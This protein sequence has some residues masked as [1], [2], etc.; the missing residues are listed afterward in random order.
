MQKL[1]PIVHSLSKLILLFSGVLCLPA[2]VSLYYDD[3]AILDFVF[4]AGFGAA[5]GLGLWLASRQHGKKKELKP[6]DGFILVVLLWFGFAVTASTP[7]LLFDANL[8]F[9]DAMFESMSALTTTGATIMSG[10]DA[11]PPSIN[12]WRHFLN[13]IGGM[14]IIVLAVAILPLLGVGGMQLYKAETP[15]P[16]KDSKL[17]PRIAQ[18]AKHLWFIYAVITLACALC[19][20]AA[21]MSWFDAVCHAMATL[22]LGGFSTHDASVGYFNSV[23]IEVILSCF[24]VIAAT[25]FAMHFVAW[26]KKSL[27]IYLKDTETFSMIAL[28]LVSILVMSVYLWHS[29]VY[30]FTVALRHVSFNLISIATCSGFA[31]VNFGVWPMFVPLWMLFLSGITASSGSTGGGI[32]MI[33][34]LIL[35]KQGWRE[36]GQLLHPQAYLPLKINKKI[37][38]DSVIFSVLGF[39]FVYFIIVIAST[40]ILLA[41]GLDLLTAFSATIACINNA[42]LGLGQVGPANTYAVLN[43][44]Q[45]WVLTLVMLLGR[46]EIFTILILFTRQFWRK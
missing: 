34:T 37:I 18:T 35:S 17:A 27:K 5:T 40:F 12:F 46:L 19:L 22:S 10:L 15:G 6:K 23:T 42:G 11:L 39:I 44:F 25:N 43:D 21:G 29:D 31:S 26:Q 36:M 33:R 7:F 24:M 14:G 38:P 20:R 41:S 32:K 8:S 28:I 1:F 4:S 9:A 30:S 45:I 3:G 13:W 16:M 2:L